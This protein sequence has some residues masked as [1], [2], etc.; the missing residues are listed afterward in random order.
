MARPAKP[1]NVNS[2]HRS[3]AEKKTRSAVEAQ[4][5]T[6]TGK[7]KPP[8]YLTESQREIYYFILGELDETKMLANLDNFVLTKMAVNIDRQ[9]TIIQE[10]NENPAAMFERGRTQIKSQLDSEFFRCCN[11]LGMSPQA[12]AKLSISAVKADAPKKTLIDLLHEDEDE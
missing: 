8:E 5:N 4:L 10:E 9:R 12:R 7:L 6:G 11:E 2:S 3:T 1:A